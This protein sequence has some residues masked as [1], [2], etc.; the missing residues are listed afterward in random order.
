MSK[1]DKTPSTWSVQEKLLAINLYDKLTYEG[2]SAAL[3]EHGFQRTAKAVERFFSRN[4]PWEIDEEIEVEESTYNPNS[5]LKTS[6]GDKL[7]VKSIY[8]IEFG[9]GK[10]ENVPVVVIPDTHA[11]FHDPYAIELACKIIEYVKPASIIYLGDDVDW[12]QISKYSKDPRRI[13]QA[14]AEVKSWQSN[15]DAAFTSAA[16]SIIRRYK[17][18]GNHEKRLY[19]YYCDSPEIMGF[20][21]MQMD[22]IIG[23]DKNFKVIPNL[24]IIED[25]IIWRNRF[26]FK[27]GDIVRKFAGWTAK[28]ELEK[29]GLNGISGHVHRAAQYTRT[30]RGKAMTW[31]EGGCLC[32]LNPEYMS[33]PNWQQAITVIWFNG[34]K[35]TDYFHPD[36]IQFVNYQAVALGRYFEVTKRSYNGK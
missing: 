30:V 5:E 2:I 15:I 19:K 3:S 36:L 1:I 21:G 35:E 12:M 6:W 18:L 16:S 20:A 24:Q 9:D 26:M 32:K 34:N 8:N 29:E 22:A 31:L 13:L 17:L 23:L 14:D 7:L 4:K 28:S 33:N 25:E 11:P 10:T 27:H